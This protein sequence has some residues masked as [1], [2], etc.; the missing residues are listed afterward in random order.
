MS[1]LS[2]Q[3]GG[4]ILIVIRRIEN[5]V[6]TFLDNYIITLSYFYRNSYKFSVI[7]NF[8]N[9]HFLISYRF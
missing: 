1:L 3:L 7:C 9:R 4:K 6:I 8:S 2:V 5:Y